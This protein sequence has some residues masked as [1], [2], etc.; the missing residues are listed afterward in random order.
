MV[1]DVGRLGASDMDIVGMQ[2]V[3]NGREVHLFE[4]TSHLAGEFD[5]LF[6]HLDERDERLIVD[7][8]VQIPGLYKYIYT[9]VCSH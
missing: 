4:R 3:R 5:L 2:E 9:H 7:L 6:S 1:R 8:G